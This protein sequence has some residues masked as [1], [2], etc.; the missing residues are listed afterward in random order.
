MKI[1]FQQI[2]VFKE[3]VKTVLGDLYR[4]SRV[5]AEISSVTK[6][7]HQSGDPLPVVVVVVW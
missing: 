4:V 6:F 3:L 2:L 5:C 7:R 1:R